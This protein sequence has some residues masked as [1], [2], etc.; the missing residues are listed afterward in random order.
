MQT[1]WRCRNGGNVFGLAQIKELKLSIFKII[2]EQS[3]V[4]VII[5][6]ELARHLMPQAMELGAD[7]FW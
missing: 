5:E 6:P 3:R 4:P 7:E 1:F 2:I